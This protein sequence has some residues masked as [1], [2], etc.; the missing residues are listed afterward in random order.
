MTNEILIALGALGALGLLAS[1]LLCLVAK[2]FNVFEDPRVGQVEEVLPGANC[3]GC[4]FPGCHGMADACVKAK[5]AANSLEGLLCPVG[6]NEVMG[7]VAG[8]L[9]LEAGAAEPKVAVVRCNGNICARPKVAVFDGAKPW[10]LQ[11]LPARPVAPSVASVWATASRLASLMPFTST[12]RR[13]CQR[14]MRR[15]VLPVVLVPRHVRS[16]SSSCARRVP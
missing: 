3:G 16:S 11:P 9:G 13:V 6:G 8:I 12:P 14:S 4:G 15:S 2:K 7:K 5:D 1:L 10:Q